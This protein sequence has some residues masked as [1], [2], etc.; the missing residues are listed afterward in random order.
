MPDLNTVPAA[1]NVPPAAPAPRRSSSEQMPPP[2]IP[3]SPS[4]SNTLPPSYT[5]T[6][7][8][9]QFSSLSLPSP[10]LLPANTQPASTQTMGDNSG[11]GSGPGPSRLPRPLTAVDLH[12]Q[13]EKEQEAVVCLPPT[14]FQFPSQ[15]ISPRADKA[16]PPRL[17]V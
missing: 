3:S 8:P 14:Q 1:P 12:L 2:P 11:V 13:L 7:N 17:T 16:S 10:Q 9:H 5:A 4:L 6:V 15:L